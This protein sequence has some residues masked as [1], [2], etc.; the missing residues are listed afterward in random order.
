L[1]DSFSANEFLTPTEIINEEME[2]ETMEDLPFVAQ[3]LPAY[4]AFLFSG[5]LAIP[6]FILE[7][8]E[9]KGKNLMV[10]LTALAGLMGFFIIVGA[11]RNL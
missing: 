7:W 10:I 9:K 8:K 2:T 11:L 6:T 3:L 5:L 1:G 4:F